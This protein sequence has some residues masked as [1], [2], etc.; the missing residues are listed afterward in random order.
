LGQQGPIVRAFA[1]DDQADA[2]GTMHESTLPRRPVAAHKPPQPPPLPVA[3]L[4]LTAAPPARLAAT[5]LLARRD[6]VANRDDSGRYHDDRS[7][8]R[9][10]NRSR[11]QS[12][13][14]YVGMISGGV[15]VAGVIAGIL[16]WQFGGKKKEVDPN[17]P[18]SPEEIHKRVAAS[19]TYIEVHV[20]GKKGVM[21]GS[22]CLID[23]DRR[24]VLT[25]NHVIDGGAKIDV[26]FAKYD[27]DGK[28]LSSKSDYGPAD[29]ISAKVLKTDPSKDLAILELVS[30][31]KDARVMPLAAGSPVPN[32]EVYTVGGSPAESIGLWIPSKGNVREVQKHRF[33]IE[34]GQIDAWVIQ[35]TNPINHGDSG[36]ALVNRKCE[37]VGVCCANMGERT[38]QGGKTIITADLVRAFIDVREVKTLLGP[39][40]DT[41]VEPKNTGFDSKKPEIKIEPKSATIDA[42]KLIGKWTLG[43]GAEIE[44]TRDG[45]LVLTAGAD[46]INGTYRLDKDKLTLTLNINGKEDTETMT[47]KLLTDDR[48]VTVEATGK[49]LEMSRVK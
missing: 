29:A 40:G 25:A 45:R 38:D 33:P 41:K 36:G 20:P 28:L 24:L 14:L 9:R 4:S 11:K 2:E 15:L 39:L 21:L 18:L 3:A 44:F 17:A 7:G 34:T 48:L 43:K 42:N 23:R 13:Q 10:S 35:T 12:T 30:I 26:F 32:E 37:L 22:G 6:S 47:I 31:P 46:R 5:P 16:I 1:I 19:A 27:K 8:A 49:E